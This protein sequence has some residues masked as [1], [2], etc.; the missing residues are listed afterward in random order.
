MLKWIF[1]Q[2]ISISNIECSSK[3]ISG[4]IK[5]NKANVNWLLS[6]DKEFMQKTSKIQIKTAMGQ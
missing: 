5:L 1:G 6:I 2:K 3:S 4:S